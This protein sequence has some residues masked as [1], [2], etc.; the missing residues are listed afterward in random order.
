M[1]VH[2]ISVC[3]S[4]AS[5]STECSMCESPSSASEGHGWLQAGRYLRGLIS[6]ISAA[7]GPAV[8][9]GRPARATLWPLV[10]QQE[11]IMNGHLY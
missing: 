3:L 6:H 10:K 11:G 8:V 4:V 9:P 2:A 1:M 5:E 7:Q